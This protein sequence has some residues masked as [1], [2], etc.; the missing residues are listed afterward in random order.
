MSIV[1]N[2]DFLKVIKSQPQLCAEGLSTPEY[3]ASPSR[4]LNFPENR[5]QFVETGFA[6]FKNACDFLSGCLLRKTV[7][8]KMGGSYGLKH[9]AERWAGDYISNGALI[10]A[11][12]HLGI[13]FEQDNDSPNVHLAV[14]SKCPLVLG[15]KA[16]NVT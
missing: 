10:A 6:E 1:T 14:S 8:R 5:Q 3:W 9:K 12:I 16:S 15:K 13:R 7:N 2:A 11:A 4:R